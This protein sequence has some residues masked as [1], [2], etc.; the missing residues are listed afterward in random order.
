MKTNSTAEKRQNH[1]S[2]DPSPI[3]RRSG[4]RRIYHGTAVGHLR[5]LQAVLFGSATGN[6]R[7]SRIAAAAAALV[8]VTLAGNSVQGATAPIVWNFPSTISG[9]SDVSLAGTLFGAANTGGSGVGTIVVNGVPFIALAT[10]GTT[11]SFT[12][13]NFTLTDSNNIGGS[14]SF[15]SN[16]NPFNSLSN[17]AYKRLLESA[18]TAG[19]KPLKLTINGL[20]A[21]R[22]YLVELW[23][24]SSNDTTPTTET[25]TAMNS[26]S[27]QFN[28]TA[29][30]G[31]V[32]QFVTG[33]F[34]A[35]STGSETI[36]LNAMTPAGGT[37]AILNAVEVRAVPEPTVWE[38]LALGGTLLA[39]AM[40]L[41]GRRAK[42]RREGRR[43]GPICGAIAVMATVVGGFP[44]RGHDHLGN[45]DRHFRRQRRQHGGNTV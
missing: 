27:L 30:T 7:L 21:G 19:P 10:D 32:G 22:N 5:L 18:S 24:N 23:V 20:T 15:G 16:S 36:S 28:T 35:N 12:S 33:T 14:N 31:G 37:D 8:L 26:T 34:T 2:L 43:A 11:N 40:L 17:V 41:R 13:G 45:T 25:V 4:K 29:T 44:A 9:F 39:A 38:M 6:C 1:Y 42:L 3:G